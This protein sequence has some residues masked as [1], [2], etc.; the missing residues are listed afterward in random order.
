MKTGQQA[1]N[2]STFA[3]QAT[4]AKN[5]LEV[6]TRSNCGGCAQPWRVL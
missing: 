4:P 5:K 2:T 6:A 1:S 3:S